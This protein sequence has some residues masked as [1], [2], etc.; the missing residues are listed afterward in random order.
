[1]ELDIR[2]R[3]VGSVVVTGVLAAA[4]LTVTAESGSAA[5]QSLAVAFASSTGAPA[6][7]Y[8]RGLLSG[9][10]PDFSDSANV[11]PLEPYEWR[12]GDPAYIPTTA[13]PPYDYF[14]VYPAVNIA[15]P[16]QVEAIASDYIM[17][18]PYDSMT[19]FNRCQALSSRAAGLGQHPDWDLMNEPDLSS[20]S[21]QSSST[22]DWDDC[23]DGVRSGDPTAR[24]VGPSIASPNLSAVETFLLNQKAKNRLPDVVTWHFSAAQNVES[25]VT[26]IRNFMAANGISARPVAINEVMYSGE[27]GHPGQAVAFFAAAERAK[28]MVSHACWT[29]AGLPPGYG[30][31]TCDQPMLDGL[32]DLNQN[33][34]AQW[35]AYADYAAMEGNLAPV[36]STDASQVDGLATASSTKATVLIGA[37]DNF[38]GGTANVTLSG[39]GSLAF[40]PGSS[41]NVRI[42]V[43]T[44]SPGL[45]PTTQTLVSDQTLS[46][47]GG[48]LTI[49]VALAQYSAARLTITG[50]GSGLVD[51]AW[52]DVGGIVTDSPAIASTGSGNLYAFVRGQDGALYATTYNGSTWAGWSGSGWNGSN[53][54]LG[55]PT[56][57]TFLGAPSAVAWGGNVTVA[58]RGTDNALWT[59]TL[60]GGSWSSWASVGGAMT[61]SPTITSQNSSNL[62]VFIRGTNHHLFQ[63]TFNGS[64]WGGWSDL[65]GPD[66]GTFIGDPTA[67]SRSNGI[68]TVYVRTA[69]NSISERYWTTGG[70][71]SPG[72][73]DIGGATTSSPN[74]STETS[75]DESVFYRGTDGALYRNT[76]SG[77]WSGWTKVG[78]GGPTN[79]VMTGTPA[80]VSTGA[81][82][83]DVLVW[84]ADGPVYHLITN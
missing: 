70:G 14:N 31:W 43:Q 77:G 26:T 74:V 20:W 24:I 25:D 63:N 41:G 36:T 30:S 46:Y 64:S 69:S 48:S 50:S 80:T 22:T 65:G 5:T 4:L 27:V 83:T 7:G 21:W 32:L 18:A 42:A 54:A 59:S 19:W 11:A 3:R 6:I 34:R 23:Y 29:E 15:A 62:E 16:D 76:W 55:G 72:W 75:G 39:L 28:A 33:R 9:I 60:S 81:G 2:I 38:A 67:A 84:S 35:Y 68:I 17:T 79:G 12:L 58:V 61:S 52:T 10:N 66:G 82:R 56:G 53:G 51:T 73:S 71:W 78:T 13:T 47:S 44:L 49:S 1:M 57:G 8:G 45:S 37:N 40:L